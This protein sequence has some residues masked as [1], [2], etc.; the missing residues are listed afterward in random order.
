MNVIECHQLSKYYYRKRA[1]HNLS[2]TIKEHTITGLIGRNGAGKTTLLRILAGYYRPS[3]GNPKSLRDTDFFFVANR[4]TSHLSNIA[5]LLT[6]SLYA[7]ITVPLLGSLFKLIIYLTTDRSLILSGDVVLSAEE[8][9]IGMWATTMAVSLLSAIGY[10]WSTLIQLVRLFIIVLPAIF[11]SLL[12]LNISGE[13]ELIYMMFQFYAEETSLLVY[14]C[15]I[16]ATLVV[17][18]TSVVILTSRLEVGR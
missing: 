17:L 5:F 3:S 15:K 16:I 2:F 10:L 18:Y 13:F 12:M 14:S 1:L 4:L 6:V 9:A 7:G 11:I 8:Y